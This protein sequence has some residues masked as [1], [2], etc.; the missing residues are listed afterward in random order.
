MPF[1]FHPHQISGLNLMA[2][3]SLLTKS[4][5]LLPQ[6]LSQHI[7]PSIPFFMFEAPTSFLP[8]KSSY[9]FPP[10]RLYS[11][12]KQV[13][14]PCTLPKVVVLYLVIW[15]MPVLE[16]LNL[17]FSSKVQIHDPNR[18]FSIPF[19]N[20]H[21]NGK[22]TPKPTTQFMPLNPAL[23]FKMNKHLDV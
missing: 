15:S 22:C 8:W 12:S 17:D 5:C 19:V 13:I 9:Y 14:L 21:R 10:I 2:S 23:F 1:C 18:L 16:S 20:Y 7:W 3:D 4:N 11:F 6:L